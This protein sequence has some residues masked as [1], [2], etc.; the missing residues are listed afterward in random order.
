MR[1]IGRTKTLMSELLI[2]YGPWGA[3]IAGIAAFFLWF[4]KRDEVTQALLHD[5]IRK[6]REELER[7]KKEFH[8]LT[9]ASIAAIVA[10]T[11]AMRS[12]VENVH[13]HDAQ[14]REDHKRLLAVRER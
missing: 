14:M 10:S 1:S 2:E 8:E 5:L 11:D 3:V 6:H 7:D 13:G 12:V 9:R 4:R